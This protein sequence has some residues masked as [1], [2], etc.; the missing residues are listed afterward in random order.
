M[1]KPSRLI[2]VQNNGWTNDVMST[3]NT[4]VTYCSHM[5]NQTFIH[6]TENLH[7][8]EIGPFFHPLFFTPY[9]QSNVIK[10]FTLLWQNWVWQ[11]YTKWYP[12]STDNY[13]VENWLMKWL[14]HRN[15]IQAHGIGVIQCVLL[16]CTWYWTS[17]GSADIQTNWNPEI[18]FFNSFS[19]LG[20][21]GHF[22]SLVFFSYSQQH[23][24]I[25]DKYT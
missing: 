4:I 6:R 11:K 9:E 8:V 10:M 17:K 5:T 13:R 19:Q 24:V 21:V 25:L 1:R 12:Y 20:L 14:I 15:P 23:K 16:F 3:Y 18:L 7:N 22:S 2:F